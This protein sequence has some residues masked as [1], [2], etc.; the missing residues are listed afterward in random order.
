MF[1]L[2]NIFMRLP[3]NYLFN[4]WNICT[5]LVEQN[6]KRV[7]SQYLVVIKPLILLPLVFLLFS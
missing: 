7:S 5:L 6:R 4:L 2:L 3:E 1:Y